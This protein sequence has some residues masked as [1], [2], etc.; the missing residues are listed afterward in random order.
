MTPDVL[1]ESLLQA[2]GGELESLLNQAA[3]IPECLVWLLEHTARTLPASP[4]EAI[5]AAEI[6]SRLAALQDNYKSGAIGYRSIAQG[7]RVL[8]RHAEALVSFLQA[9][10]LAQT[11]GDELLAVQVQIGAIEQNAYQAWP[12][13]RGDCACKAPCG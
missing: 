7:L 2:V 3:S 6:A 9:S 4:D 8:G 13:C 12:T 11:A 10:D 1:G 5:H